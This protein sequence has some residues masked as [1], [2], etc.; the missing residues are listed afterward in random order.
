MAN[1]VAG[2]RVQGRGAVPRRKVA[3]AG[4]AGDITDV[5]QQPGCAGRA[6]TVQR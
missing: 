1:L 6:D 4:E 2:G 5:D 3:L